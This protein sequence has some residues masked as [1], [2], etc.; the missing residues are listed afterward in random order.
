[1]DGQHWIACR[2]GFFLSVRVLS[3]LFRRLFLERLTAAYQA[4]RL[5]FLRRPDR[6][7]QA[8]SLQSSPRRT[9]EAR[10]GSLCQA[11]FWRTRR[12]ARLPVPL[13]SPDRYCQQPARRLRRRAGDLQMEGLPGQG[14]RPLQA[15]DTG[16]QRVH[17]PLPDP[18]AAR[19]VHR[20]RHYGL[21]ANANRA[22]NIA[23]ARRLLGVPDPTP[24]NSE[25]DGTENPHEDD[26][27]NACP[28]CGGRMVIVETFR[29]PTAAVA[30]PLIGLDSS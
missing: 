2:P 12:C 19:R 9:A 27:W 1:M 17:P 29:R 25:S 30:D 18:R 14:R 11:A 20:I 3:R 8:S 10:L 22:G 28:C 13:H 15:Y 23:L 4:G 5:E 21:F 7:G 26:E 16:R 6:A 24:S